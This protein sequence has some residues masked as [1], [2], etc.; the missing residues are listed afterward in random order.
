[1]TL[2]GILLIICGIVSM[3]M[4]CKRNKTKVSATN[5]GRQSELR[6]HQLRVMGLKLFEYTLIPTYVEHLKEHPDGEFLL[7]DVSTWKRNI[8]SVV[9][10]RYIDWDEISCE[11]FGDSK[12][13]CLFLYDFPTP[14]D[15]P[16]AKY[17]A[18]YINKRKQIYNYYTLEKSFGGYMLCSP[19]KEYHV[20]Y[21]EK[22]DMSKIE[23]IKEICNIQNIDESSLL[24][25]R[26][27]KSKSSVTEYVDLSGKVNKEFSENDLK[28]LVGLKDD[29]YEEFITNHPRT[30]V[31]FYDANIPSKMM[32]NLLSE[33]ATDHK[34]KIAVGIYNVYGDNNEIIR[35]KMNIMAMPTFLIYKNGV[36]VQKHIGLCARD[37][38]KTMF[39]NLLL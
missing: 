4:L 20:N 38:M 33:F 3:F 2:Y 21:G 13:E 5:P 10:W 14:F 19:S 31:C 39:E 12:T 26:L 24:Q 7:V 6:E 32:V 11:I 23:F 15:I 34:D 35:A 37:A 22:G 18:V 16:L 9:D 1:M 8:A 27:A 36:V 28:I 30:I 17:G 25:W 29:D